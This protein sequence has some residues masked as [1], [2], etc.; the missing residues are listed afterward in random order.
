MHDQNRGVMAFN[1]RMFFC[2]IRE[3]EQEIMEPRIIQPIVGAFFP[4]LTFMSLKVF[5]VIIFQHVLMI[6]YFDIKIFFKAK[7]FKFLLSMPLIFVVEHLSHAQGFWRGI[8]LPQ[9]GHT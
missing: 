2:R 5:F 7:K 6:T 4:L 1:K 8:L 3:G 9:R